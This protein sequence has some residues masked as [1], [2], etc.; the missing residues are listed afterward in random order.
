VVP[1]V[2]L[3]ADLD[4]PL[5]DVFAEVGVWSELEGLG[6]PGVLNHYHVGIAA[7]NTRRT[8]RTDGDHFCLC[9]CGLP[10]RSAIGSATSVGR[11]SC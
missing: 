8:R 1:V 10:G 3:A 9:R 6:C 11:G 2:A 4:A 7:R 5:A